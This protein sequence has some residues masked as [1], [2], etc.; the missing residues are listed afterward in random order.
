[1]LVG[2]GRR[3]NGERSEKRAH[4]KGQLF[5]QVESRARHHET[6]L[7]GEE[8]EK[9]NSR[10]RIHSR[11]YQLDIRRSIHST[12]LP[13]SAEDRKKFRRRRPDR[14]REEERS[15]SGRS[16]VEGRELEEPGKRSALEGEER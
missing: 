1:M 12:L 11:E 13:L 2:G 3:E 4:D 8:E 6:F 10:N 16:Q 9:K 5:S 7:G 14:R 15:S